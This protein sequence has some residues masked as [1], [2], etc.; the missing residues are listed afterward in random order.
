MGTDKQLNKRLLIAVAATVEYI[1]KN[2]LDNK[3]TS[4]L[5]SFVNIS[6]SLL[7]EGFKKVTGKGIKEYRIKKRME[8]AQ[9]LLLEG[10]PVK[11]IARLCLYKRQ[12]SFSAAFKNLYGVSP[13]QWLQKNS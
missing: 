9:R 11:Q 6:R 4:E 10:K 13:L 3:T 1:E 2:P 12:S 7:Q 8:F 5:A